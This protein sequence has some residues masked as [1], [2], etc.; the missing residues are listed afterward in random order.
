MKSSESTR[1]MAESSLREELE[2]RWQKLRELTE[3][4]LRALRAQ[5]EV[6]LSG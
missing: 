1:L 2:S 3:E 5:R 4:H 6:G